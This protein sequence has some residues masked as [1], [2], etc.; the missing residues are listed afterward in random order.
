MSDTLGIINYQCLNSQ[1]QPL[2]GLT[3]A[4]L[5]GNIYD[6]SPPVTTTQ[7]GSPLATIFA[8]PGSVNELVNPTT[9][10][11]NTVTTDG[12]GNLCS[13]VDGVTT[14]GVCVGGGGYE[15]PPKYVTLQIY[16]PGIVGQLLVSIGQL[17]SS[18][19]GGDD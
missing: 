13:I 9:A 11:E 12:F 3:V 7:P 6:E 18:G 19:G 16:G 8:D 14:L 1:G 2:A 4:V 15:G 5:V 10:G 17:P